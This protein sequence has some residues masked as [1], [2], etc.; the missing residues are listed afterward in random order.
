M[1]KDKAWTGV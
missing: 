1:L